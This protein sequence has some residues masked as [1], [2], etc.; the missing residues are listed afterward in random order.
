M[1]CC[2]VSW[3]TRGAC[4]VAVCHDGGVY[5]DGDV[6]CVAMCHDGGVCFDG[7]VCC[8]AMSVS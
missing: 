5:C 6:C 7:D 4:S 2:S 8:V 3:L 1:L